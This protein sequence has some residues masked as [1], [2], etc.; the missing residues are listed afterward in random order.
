[1]SSKR[2]N[3]LIRDIDHEHRLFGIRLM[4]VLTPEEQYQHMEFLLEDK[5]D[6]EL[7]LIALREVCKSRD[8]HIAH[9]II[10]NL[11]YFH[12]LNPVYLSTILA[13][14]GS[15]IVSNIFAELQNPGWSPREQTVMIETVRRLHSRVCLQL[16]TDI[17]RS[18]NEPMILAAWLRYIETV[19]GSEYHVYVRTM[20]HHG[21]EKV[22]VAAARAYIATAE[23][24]SYMDIANFFDDVSIW[25]PIN[26]AH[27]LNTMNLKTKV[28]DHIVAS[29]KHADVYRNMVKE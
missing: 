27:K 23:E 2:I 4:S 16:T 15:T 9:L 24:I 11:S 3:H 5:K 25:V 19:A 12:Y 1:M 21:N 26:A 28:P 29:L 8:S 18:K 7:T 13:E 14:F 10:R 6:P 20:L 22:R 17:L